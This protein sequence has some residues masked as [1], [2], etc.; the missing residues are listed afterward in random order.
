[1]EILGPLLH[2]EGTSAL[3]LHFDCRIKSHLADLRQAEKHETNPFAIIK[4]ARSLICIGPS[5]ATAGYRGMFSME[6]SNAT[7]SDV[8]FHSEPPTHHAE[9]HSSGVSWGA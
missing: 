3:W 9:A 5:R 7:Y 2:R 8:G 4:T 6:S 1:M